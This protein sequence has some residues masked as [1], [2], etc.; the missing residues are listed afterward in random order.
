MNNCPDCKSNLESTEFKPKKS[1]HH[2]KITYCSSCGGFYLESVTVNNLS[3]KDVKRLLKLLKP[4][5]SSEAEIKNCPS[6]NVKLLR[7]TEE[8]IPLNVSIYACEK[9]HKR[10][11]PSGQLLKFKKAQEAKLKYVVEWNVPL[12]S[13]FAIILPLLLIAFIGGSIPLT[14]N[15]LK[16]SQSSQVGAED[17]MSKPVVVNVAST[18]MLVSFTTHE[19][20]KT[21][22]EYGF[23]KDN[24]SFLTISSTKN[25]FH[26]IIL[27]NLEPG[28]TYH[29]RLVVESDGKKI[30]SPLY[31]FNTSD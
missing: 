24:L 31:S 27:T 15:L 5:S 18:E 19:S 8:S 13:I 16:S 25:T 17:I 14:L 6:C 9:C 4:G 22:I 7:L 29:Y 21:G 1:N 30:T 2:H 12:K 26:K 28:K 23:F 3:L 10:W 11:F 20:A